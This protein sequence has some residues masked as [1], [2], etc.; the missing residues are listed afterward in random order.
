MASRKRKTIGFRTE[1]ELADAVNDIVNDSD[2]DTDNI[3][4][5][6]SS[7]KS[8]SESANESNISSPGL[9]RR[10]IDVT[11]TTGFS[12]N[13]RQPR[14]PPFIG[15]PG[16]QFAVENEA[17]VMS[18]FDHYIPP[19]LIERVV[20]QTNLYAQQQ[21]AKMPRPVTKHAR[22][23]EWKPVTV[24]EMKKF[25][26]L[27]FV[28]G[29]V[30][31]PKLQLYWSMR[32]IFQTPI[33]PQT[34][35]RNRFQLIQRYLHFIDNHAAGTNVDHLYKILT[36]L[37]IVVNN[38]RTNYIPGR[39]ISLDEGMLG[40]RGRLRFCVYNPSRITEY[41]TLVRMICESSIGYI[42]NLEIYDGKCGP[43][44]ETVGFLLE[45]YEGKGY[46]LYQDN[47]YNSIHQTNELL[48]K[49]IRVCGT[50][51]VNCG[52]PKDMIEEAK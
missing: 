41:V 39:K 37:D 43:L 22:S 51:R 29:I 15:N 11:P 36:I 24:M 21:I 6:S 38:F 50:I 3:P 4:E 14:I 42:C 33:F 44:A 49:L 12:K 48:Q 19:E 13:D 26:G 32:G 31:K 45:P 2:S 9:S 30:R 34:M 1:E 7:E 52:L 46:H 16:V 40:W 8:E 18:Y 25:L 17:D 20:D 28:T 5:F 10:Q 23:E 47:Y 27:I 35:S